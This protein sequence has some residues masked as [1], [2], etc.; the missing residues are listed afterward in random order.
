MYTA[1]LHTAIDPPWTHLEPLRIGPI[2]TGEG[3][4]QAFVLVKRDGLPHL[5]IDA[6]APFDGPF[7]ELTVW[8]SLVVLGWSD[9]VHLIDPGTRRVTNIVCDGYF[10]NLYI[11][12][13]CLLIASSTELIR[14]DA[15]A[16]E[17]WRCAGLAVDGVLVH[18][19][20]EGVIEGS[21]EW[22]PPGG[23]QPFRIALDTGTPIAGE[24]A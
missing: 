20:A 22:D 15:Q 10:G 19:V 18:N 6:Y 4:P 8:Q 17:T 1:T 16:R 13:D 21:G 11:D 24:Q 14:I 12:D 9:A 23:W 7:R 5:R 3:T 2:P